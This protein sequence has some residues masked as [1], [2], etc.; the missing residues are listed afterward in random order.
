MQK[1]YTGDRIEMFGPLEIIHV[2]SEKFF[3]MN[4]FRAG[5]LLILMVQNE[6]CAMKP[7]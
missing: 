5:L 6:T 4:V 1:L 2:Y 3:K 7:L